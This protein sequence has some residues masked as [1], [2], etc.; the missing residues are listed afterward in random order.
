MFDECGRPK[1]GVFVPEARHYVLAQIEVELLFKTENCHY[2]C[3]GRTGRREEERAVYF[4]NK[5]S[6]L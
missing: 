4:P 2:E 3:P 6:M 5:Y 1:V